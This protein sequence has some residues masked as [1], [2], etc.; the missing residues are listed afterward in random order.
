MELVLDKYVVGQLYRQAGGCL[1]LPVWEDNIALINV[2]GMMLHPSDDSKRKFWIIR[3]TIEQKKINRGNTHR[4]GPYTDSEFGDDMKCAAEQ[5]G[6]AGNFISMLFEKQNN[7]SGNEFLSILPRGY[8]TGAILRTAIANKIS[9]QKAFERLAKNLD[10]IVICI[11]GQEKKFTK[12]SFFNNIWPQY[13][14]VA[15]LWASWGYFHDSAAETPNAER[16]FVDQNFDSPHRRASGKEDGFEGF[17][18]LADTYF[19]Q[20]VLRIRGGSPNKESIL[21][22]ADLLLVIHPYNECFQF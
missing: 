1:N 15:H 7:S 19:L 12:D 4:L 5:F 17:L 13:K 14:K 9:P 2:Y 22:P 21:A 18:R 3:R 20:A 8:L 10:E 11:L 16:P 6:G